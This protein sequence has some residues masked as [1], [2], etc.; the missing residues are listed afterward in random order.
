MQADRQACL[1][2]LRL[3]MSQEEVVVV[4]LYVHLS[5]VQHLITNEQLQ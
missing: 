2:H 5:N 1:K 3:D 4:L